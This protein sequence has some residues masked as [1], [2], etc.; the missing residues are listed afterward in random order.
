MGRAAAKRRQ[1]GFGRRHYDNLALICR[2]RRRVPRPDGRNR[3]DCRSNGRPTNLNCE[4]VSHASPG[5]SG[6]EAKN[7]RV[8]LGN[9]LIEIKVAGCRYCVIPSAREYYRILHDG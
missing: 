5:E 3:A 8:L 1:Q 9:Y 2:L 4:Q 6:Y 7:I